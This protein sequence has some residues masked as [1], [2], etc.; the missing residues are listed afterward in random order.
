MTTRRDFLTG[1][2]SAGLGTLALPG[3]AALAGARDL[4]PRGTDRILAESAPIGRYGFILVDVETGKV[5]EA[6]N[7]DDLFIPASL[8][9]IPTSFAAMDI[10][11][12]S[13]SFA[14]RIEVD[15]TLEN[16]VLDGDLH[17][18]GGGD[19]GLDTMDLVGLA[20]QVQAAGIRQV[21]GRFIYYGAAL[22]QT[23]WLDKTQPWQAPYN[24]SMGGL[25]L[26]YN[27]VQFRWARQ[28]GYLRVRGAAVSDGKVL[29]APS[30]RFRVVRDGP[31]IDHLA[32]GGV[33]TWSLNTSILK[34]DGQRWLPVRKPGA[35]TAGV[36]QAVCA[37]LG[38][39]LPAPEP[40]TGAPKGRKIADHRSDPVYKMLHGMMKF[41]T[42]LTAEALGAS[43][44]YVTGERP[45]SIVQAAG[46]T[47]LY[48]ANKVG[49]IGGKGW[50]GYSLAN[51]SGLSVRSRA[52]P[53][54]LAYLL[55]EGQRRWGDK[56]LALF[57]NK[58]MTPQRMGLDPGLVPP[59]H[60]ILGKTGSMN[61]V[62]GL[63][64]FA[65]IKDR[66][67]AYAFMANEDRS[68]RILDERFTPYSDPTPTA[69]A[70]WSRRTKNFEREMLAEWVKRYSV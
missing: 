44:S 24:P 13:A 29:P 56:Y 42:N 5:V 26:N 51:H 61:F 32:S 4:Q 65:L 58:S 16:G 1:A 18:I 33:E 30:V 6:R 7:A 60:Y 2:A 67:M 54:Q 8:S 63:A 23:R 35:F 62:R 59:R 55:R 10:F 49:S 52:T 15:G 25:N 70:N 68:R 43:A 45:K 39:I 11:G 48:T 66:P 47:T 64:G 19:P 14:T 20:Q 31:E 36:F 53:R 27:R 28:G 38:I 21:N 12:E 9:K 34:G 37:E 40:A 22:P 50:V 69:A 17:L 46:L 3:G 57:T 41:S